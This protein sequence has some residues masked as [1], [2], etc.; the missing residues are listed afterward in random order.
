M[1][2]SGRQLVTQMRTQNPELF[3]AATAAAN[4]VTGDTIPI[5]DSDQQPPQPPPTV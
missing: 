5:T 2:Y 1:I 4:D 3:E